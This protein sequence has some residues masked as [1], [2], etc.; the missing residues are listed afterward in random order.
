MK[1]RYAIRK[2]A[3]ILVLSVCNIVSAF[4]QGAVIGYADGR[5]WIGKAP[6]YLPYTN[7]PTAVQLQKLT[8][9]IASDM[10]KF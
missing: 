10:S 3:A 1:N 9:V 7:F 4:A 8:H 5:T 2:Y 6:L